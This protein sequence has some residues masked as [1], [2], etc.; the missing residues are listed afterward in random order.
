MRNHGVKGLEQISLISQSYSKV[1]P[2]QHLI[3]PM[4]E[5]KIRAISLKSHLK[6]ANLWD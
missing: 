1:N 6:I 2:G 5:V 4:N 3:V